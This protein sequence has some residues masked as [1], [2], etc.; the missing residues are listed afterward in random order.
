MIIKEWEYDI[1]LNNLKNYRSLLFYGPDRGLV[2]D[3]TDAFL[4][5]QKKKEQGNIEVIKLMPDDF[6]KTENLLFEITHQKPIFFNSCIIHINLDLLKNLK[7]VLIFLESLN[8][9]ETNFLL[10]EAGTLTSEAKLLRLFKTSKNLG[11]IPCY[12][13]NENK[14]YNFVNSYC[15]EIKL[16]ISKENIKFLC[17]KLGNDRLV[18]KNEIQKLALFSNNKPL[19][20]DAVLKGVGDNSTI[21]LDHICDNLL[22]KSSNYING[23]VDKI[24]ENG[25]SYILLIRSLNKHLLLLFYSKIL[26]IKDVKN[27]SPPLHFSRH[28]KIQ[29]Q[30][31]NINLNSLAYVIS[32]LDELETVCKKEPSMA[33]IFVKK[34]VL[35]ISRL[36]IE[37][38]Y[39]SV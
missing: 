25:I 6:I 19:S 20:Y 17:A 26:G 9:K 37:K 29:Q 7:E 16:N 30:L 32:Q 23:I 12:L 5:I 22:V 35:N 18:T 10:L 28:A 8:E 34:F 39:N 33:N 31:L 1:F 21:R 3:K 13:D 36:S 2:K 15:K 11:V 38:F 4:E 24:F 27:F 14:L